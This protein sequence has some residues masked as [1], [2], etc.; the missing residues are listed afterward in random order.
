MQ[1]DDERVESGLKRNER[2]ELLG[3]NRRFL[4][5][6]RLCRQFLVMTH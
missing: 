2:T 3:S 4:Y 1:W 6:L 5:I